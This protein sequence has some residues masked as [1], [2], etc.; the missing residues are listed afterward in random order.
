MTKESSVKQSEAVVDMEKATEEGKLDSN[1]VGISDD[2]EQSPGRKS[3]IWQTVKSKMKITPKDATPVDWKI[4]G[5]VFLSLFTSSFSLT[6]LFPFLPE[7]ILFFGYQE[8][9][10]GYYAGLVA[11]MVFAGRATGSFF[12]GWLSD[13]MGRKPV[14]LM[15]IFGNGFFCLLFGFTI[16]LPMAL[17]TRFFAGLTNGSVGIAKT[18]LYEI[19]DDTNQAIGMSILSM[20]W[21]AGII[22]GPAAGGLLASPAK[23]YPSVFSEDGAF[24]RFPYLL[25]SLIVLCTCIVV[26]VI[27]V[28]FLPETRKKRQTTLNVEVEEEN[29]ELQKLSPN[30]KENQTS[31]VDRKITMSMEDLHCHT[32]RAVYEVKLHQSCHNLYT[33]RDSHIAEVRQRSISENGELLK[34]EAIAEEDGEVEEKTSKSILDKIR[35]TT[36]IKIFSMPECREAIF[37]YT[38]FSFS[39]IGYEEIFT[40]WAST[41]TFYDGLGFDAD[42]I[43]MVLGIASVPMLVLNLFIYPWLN[44]LIGT[45]M[46]LYVAVGNPAP[47]HHS[48][49][50]HD[51]LLF[52][53]NVSVCQQLSYH[54]HC[55]IRQ[56]YR[57]DSH[58]ILKNLG[59]NDRGK[60]VCLVHLE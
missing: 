53:C 33:S 59:T 19:S 37:L 3:S 29:E 1:D 22:L 42:E 31:K 2:Q 10:K 51:K 6:F 26:F 7:M 18:I 17:V 27:D 21:G 44:R 35:S 38:I 32:E 43:G 47:C 20:S 56:W 36:L 52:Y 45:K 23:R 9:E 4:I 34:K 40:V 28:M 25:P 49:E 54:P 46:F 39:A 55:R 5:L 14:M 30:T 41:K 13:R 50:N 57:H 15:T 11:S 16:N 24:G 8:T 48:T 12:W 58:S 60:C